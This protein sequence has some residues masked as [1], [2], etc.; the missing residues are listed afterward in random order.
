M[1]G[2]V[3]KFLTLISNVNTTKEIMSRKQRLVM[4]LCY[5]SP[6]AEW[7]PQVIDVMITFMAKT[8]IQSAC[9]I[10]SLR[11]AIHLIWLV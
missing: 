1:H 9:L 7:A 4:M 8:T 11:L 6:A 10:L 2:N 5:S 3:Y